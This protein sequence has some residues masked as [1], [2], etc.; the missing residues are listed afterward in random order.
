MS[1]LKRRTRCRYCGAGTTRADGF[2]TTCTREG[3][4]RIYFLT[5]ERSNGW[6][7]WERRQKILAS[8]PKVREPSLWDAYERTKGL[9]I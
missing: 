7:W 5:G 6:E 4:A 9:K 8:R 2:C 1:A 3:F